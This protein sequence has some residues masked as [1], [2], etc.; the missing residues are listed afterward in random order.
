MGV[1]MCTFHVVRFRKNLHM[2]RKEVMAIQ[3]E[4]FNS[5]ERHGARLV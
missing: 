5:I 1:C 3:L 2:P 4:C